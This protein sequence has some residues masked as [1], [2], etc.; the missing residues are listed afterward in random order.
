M[1]REVSKKTSYWFWI[2]AIVMALI[3]GIIIGSI[4]NSLG[5]RYAP[6]SSEEPPFTE[7]DFDPEC[8]EDSDCNNEFEVCEEGFHV[9]ILIVAVK[10][11]FVILQMEY[12][13]NVQ[14]VLIVHQVIIVVAEFVKILVIRYLIYLITIATDVLHN[15]LASLVLMEMKRTLSLVFRTASAKVSQ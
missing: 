4:I 9:V 7:G 5:V 10:M 13:K 6:R 2:A 15:A 3:I 8:E 1:K 12:V 14:K 11:K